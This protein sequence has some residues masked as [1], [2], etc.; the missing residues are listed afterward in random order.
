MYHSIIQTSLYKY[1]HCSMTKPETN[2]TAV[3]SQFRISI[4]SILPSQ[5]QR[6]IFFL[7]PIARATMIPSLS[8]SLSSPLWRGFIEQ[9]LYIND[10]GRYALAS[11]SLSLSSSFPKQ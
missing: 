3:K 9:V 10:N 6:R 11:L 2:E 7:D 1:F 8:L 4:Q 5:A